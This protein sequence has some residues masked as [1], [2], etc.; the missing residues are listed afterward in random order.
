MTSKA[1]LLLI[2]AAHSAEQSANIYDHAGEY[3]AAQV[4]RDAAEE[5]RHAIELLTDH[6]REWDNEVA[7]VAT[8]AGH[9]LGDSQLAEI[10]ES[11]LENMTPDEAFLAWVESQPVNDP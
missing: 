9:T 6:R 11:Y 2:K 8:T 3:E 1:I 4:A 10:G 7:Q 5:I